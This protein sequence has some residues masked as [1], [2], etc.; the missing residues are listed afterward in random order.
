MNHWRI[1]CALVV[2]IVLGS[3]TS[4]GRDI[5]DPEASRPSPPEAENT[6]RSGQGDAVPQPVQEAPGEQSS[7]EDQPGPGLSDGPA[8]VPL[9]PE[10]TRH[11]TVCVPAGWDLSPITVTGDQMSLVDPDG[12]LWGWTGTFFREEA[13]E[14]SVR[15][16]WQF[17]DRDPQPFRSANGLE[18]L[19]AEGPDALDPD[20]WV[21]A[22]GFWRPGLWE[23]IVQVSA[24]GGRLA[25]V[26]PLLERI[27][28]CYQP[29]VHGDK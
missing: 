6:A 21:L 20:R 17:R 14:E 27:L 7:P 24:P 1:I 10:K 8:D 9:S 19:F 25:E 2:A 16:R 29:D 4:T 18:G 26:R 23:Q 28:T 12:E 5:Q 15:S 11:G 22:V 13:S 3:V